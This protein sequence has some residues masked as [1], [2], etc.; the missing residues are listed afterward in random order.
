MELTSPSLLSFQIPIFLLSTAFGSLEIPDILYRF[1]DTGQRLPILALN[2]L[3][4][5]PR[6]RTFAL[7]P[8]PCSCFQPFPL[9]ESPHGN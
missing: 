6:E 5:L 8:Q 9:L 7:L 4:P 2:G 3:Q 1:Y